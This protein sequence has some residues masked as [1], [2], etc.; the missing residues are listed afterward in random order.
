M[1]ANA[2]PHVEYAIAKDSSTGLPFL[3]RLAL[4]LDLGPIL[5]RR[6][7]RDDEMLLA[8]VLDL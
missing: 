4:F 1:P 5:R 3:A 8:L 6:G 2:A 7:C